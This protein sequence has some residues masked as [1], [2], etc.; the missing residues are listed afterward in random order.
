MFSL[1]TKLTTPLIVAIMALTPLSSSAAPNSNTTEPPTLVESASKAVAETEAKAK[2]IQLITEGQELAAAVALAQW[3][4]D[5]TNLPN[6]V[7]AT[8]LITAEYLIKMPPGW[9][10]ADTTGTDNNG[11][12][13]Q[14]QFALRI[15][16]DLTADVLEQIY[17]LTDRPGPAFNG[18]I[19][20]SE[21][22]AKAAIPIFGVVGSTNKNGTPQIFYK[23]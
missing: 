21:I 10:L 22:K 19:F 14:P 1:T 6:V 18:D 9:I 7:D 4:I 20:T 16:T 8:F 11:T 3:E 2:A 23:L 15:T 12:K 5:R 13:N 17:K